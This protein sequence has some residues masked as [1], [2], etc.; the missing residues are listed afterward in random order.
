MIPENF[1]RRVALV[2]LFCAVLVAGQAVGAEIIDGI[3]PD[4][5]L[6]G[7]FEENS[8]WLGAGTN[9]ADDLG[10]LP[11]TRATAYRTGGGA[12]DGS[13]YVIVGEFSASIFGVYADTGYDLRAGDI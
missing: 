2:T 5:I 1:Q 3:G 13:R 7:S 9:L 4:Y 6:N 10:S 12:T 8:D 11:I